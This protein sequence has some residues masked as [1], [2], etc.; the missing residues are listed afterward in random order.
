LNNRLLIGYGIG[1]DIVT[2]YDLKFKLE[3]TFNHLGE[4]DLYL[5]R[6]NE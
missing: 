5:H 2:A 6:N 4:S 1:V 3:F